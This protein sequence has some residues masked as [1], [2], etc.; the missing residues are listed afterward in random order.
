MKYLKTKILTEAGR[1][2]IKLRC[3]PKNSNIHYLFVFR[4]F[5]PAAYFGLI[6]DITQS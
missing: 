6:Q 4:T 5:F 3:V 1:K 2:H